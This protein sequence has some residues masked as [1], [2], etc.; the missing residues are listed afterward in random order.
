MNGFTCSTQGALGGSQV[1]RIGDQSRA[2]QG[3]R[4]CAL[5]VVLAR[6]EAE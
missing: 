2:H 4:N 1:R 6:P 3:G 5:F